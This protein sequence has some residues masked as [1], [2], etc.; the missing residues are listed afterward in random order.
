VAAR[1]QDG[2]QLI[3]SNGRTQD[4]R[5]EAGRR[6]R[7]LGFEAGLVSPGDTELYV[8]TGGQGKPLLLLH[9]YP[10]S[11]E[12]WRFVAPELAKTRRVI[13]PDLPGMGLSGVAATGYGLP[14]V[15]KDVHDIPFDS[16]R[17]YVEAVK[18]PGSISSSAGYYRAVYGALKAMRETIRRG[19]LTIPVLSVSGEASFGAAQQS[20]VEAFAANIAKQVIVPDAGHFV[21]EEQPEIL[22]SHLQSF[23]GV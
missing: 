18:R 9:G 14:E 8:A 19:K 3:S 21:A 5:R 17:P 11:G 22:I 20:F 7:E 16:W 13:V 2:D 23:F 10:Q 4:L 15:A 6:W 1:V 12:I